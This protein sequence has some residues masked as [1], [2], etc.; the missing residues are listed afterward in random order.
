MSIVSSELIPYSWSHLKWL[1]V[2]CL[3]RIYS[4]PSVSF[5]FT[6]YSLF[7]LRLYFI[8]TLSSDLTSTWLPFESITTFSSKL[9]PYPLF[10][11]NWLHFHGFVW[12]DSISTASS[13]MT[14]YLQSHLNWLHIHCSIRNESIS[15]FS[16]KLTPYTLFH[17]NWLHF[18][19]APFP[20][21]HLNWLHTL[22]LN[23]MLRRFQLFPILQMKIQRTWR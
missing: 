9:N 5:E 4:K 22:C 1:S 12:I 7:H 23:I 8:S 2:H 17:P 11:P 20:L 3:I 6:L 14:P 16:S 10:H 13:E 21:S 19:L 18:E 15:T